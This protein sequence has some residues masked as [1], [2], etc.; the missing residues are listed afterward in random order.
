VESRKARKLP[1]Q[2]KAKDGRFFPIYRDS[3]KRIRRLSGGYETVYFTIFLGYIGKA[4]QAGNS[5]GIFFLQAVPRCIIFAI[6]GEIGAGSFFAAR[7]RF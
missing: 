5:H 7:G 4:R 3:K 2:A 1:T 6:A